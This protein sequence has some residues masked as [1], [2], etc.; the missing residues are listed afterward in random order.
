MCL[1]TPAAGCGRCGLVDVW[2]PIATRRGKWVWLLSVWV[3]PLRRCVFADKT[4][5][6]ALKIFL[7]SLLKLTFGDLMAVLKERNY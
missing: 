3:W 4:E 5:A 1:S 6:S 7:T 2:Y